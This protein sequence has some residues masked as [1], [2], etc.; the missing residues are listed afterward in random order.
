M[1]QR[2][3]T[4]NK[5]EICLLFGLKIRGLLCS[6]FNDRNLTFR[7][8]D[9][10]GYF[11]DRYEKGQR[12]SRGYSLIWPT[13]GCAAGQGMGF[14]L[15]VLNRVYNFERVCNLI[16]NRVLAARLICMICLMKFVCLASIQSNEL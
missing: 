8:T 2:D 16:V 6:N 12:G 9:S 7:R 4:E 5:A 1:I 10:N 11:K 14:E 15:S 3:R 13:R